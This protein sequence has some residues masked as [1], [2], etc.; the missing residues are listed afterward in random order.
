[1][2]SPAATART[3]A[4]Q[5]A[6]AATEDRIKSNGR[7]LAPHGLLGT[8]S[9]WVVRGRSSSWLSSALV[10]AA[11]ILALSL[12]GFGHEGDGLAPWLLG[13][14]AEVP[15]D[16]LSDLESEALM[17]TAGGASSWNVSGQGDG[18]EGSQ[19]AANL[20]ISPPDMIPW[21]G[22]DEASEMPQA[23]TIAQPLLSR[24]GGL[25]GRTM[26]N[27]HD[28]AL[29]G[30]GSAASEAAV[31]RGLAWLAAH[32]WADGGWRF[33]LKNTPTCQGECRHGGNFPSTTAS[34]GLALLCFL[35][36]G[37]TH[38]EGPYQETVTNGLYYLNNRMVVTS[39]GGDL[40]DG[41]TGTMYSHA[42]ATLALTEAVA[43]TG[44]ATLT[45]PAQSAID[46]IVYA[47]H[48]NGG[49]RYRPGEPGDTTVTGWHIAAL[50][51]ALLARLEV[52]YDIW[53][54]I[55][56]FL[57]SVQL[58]RGEA[59]GYK[60]TSQSTNTTNAIGLFGR[61]IL[62]WPHDHRPLQRGMAQMANLDPRKNHMYHNYYA[63][64]I[65][66]HYGGKGWERWNKRTLKY[67]IENQARNG[68][69]NGSWYIQE[70]HSHIAG[71]LYTTTM[72]I[73][74]L[75][76]YYRYMPLYQRAFVDRAP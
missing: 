38:Q 67:L 19:I 73:M 39:L 41:E 3:D 18:V 46:F 27:R 43:M 76:V 20:T 57:D 68:H 37:Y 12:I 36:A 50:K 7:E 69:E 16:D 51:S 35:G 6:R 58:D 11:I 29:R 63:T 65:L 44:D 34:T 15:I 10:H 4:P 54:K 71:R 26:G 42:I 5:S 66:H 62:G 75:E 53:Q 60:G 32:Q 2:A 33:D 22:S 61:M 8:L 14:V 31:E 59:Y 17:V 64:Q 24:G 52:P 23:E 21:Q 28:L 9:R 40:R 55:G 47:Q 13:T 25:E 45:G 56:A 70:K 72:A 49:W 48:P 30:G 74:T 1:M